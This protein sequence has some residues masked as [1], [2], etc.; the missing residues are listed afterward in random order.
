VITTRVLVLIGIVGFTAGL[1]GTGIGRSVA[2]KAEA[3][4]ENRNL[5]TLSDNTW[6]RMKD[7]AAQSE[8]VFLASGHRWDG[9]LTNSASFVS[10]YNSGLQRCFVLISQTSL[11]AGAGITRGLFDAF[12]GKQYG[13]Y[14]W[15]KEKDRRWDTPPADCHVLSATGAGTPCKSPEEF[16]ALLK[17]YLEQST[18]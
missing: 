6:Q 13:E 16:S 18:Q 8:H 5:A 1:L 3:I 4:P 11:G 17:P 14:M 15:V 12:D 10:H 9:P 7:C 2:R